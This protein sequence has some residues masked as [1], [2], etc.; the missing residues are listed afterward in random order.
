MNLPQ[1]KLDRV[2]R[3]VDSVWSAGNAAHHLIVGQTGS[4]KSTLIKALLTLC[5]FERAL[6]LDP[7]P[8]DDRV[9]FDADDPLRWGRPVEKIGEQFGYKGERGGGSYGM[10]YRIQGQPDRRET[11]R[12]FGDALAIVAAEGHV[13][14]ALDDCRELARQ[15]RLAEEIDSVMSLGRSANTLAVLSATEASWVAGKAQSAMTWI[16]ATSGLAAA[17]S[18]AELLSWRGRELQDLVG[19]VRPHQWIYQD[20]QDGSAGACRSRRPRPR[21]S[22]ARGCQA[23]SWLPIRSARRPCSRR[24]RGSRTRARR[25]GWRS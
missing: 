8:H 15:L 7:K 16:G 2:L 19:S 22:G 17:K 1:V 9:W 25:K 20:Q 5:K 24:H 11:A 14:L 21:R 10:W 13:V 3:R 4:G 18:G 6:I 23:R 12:R